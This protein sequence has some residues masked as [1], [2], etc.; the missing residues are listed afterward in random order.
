MREPTRVSWRASCLLCLAGAGSCVS[1][2]FVP[3]GG[4]VT[5]KPVDCEIQVFSSAVPERPYV[6]MGIVEGEGSW[7]KSD[8]EDVLPKLKE[9]A[10]LAGGDAIIMQSTD[11]FAEGEDGIRVQ[12]ITAT[13]IR[14]ARQ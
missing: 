11:T 13:V 3:T 2:T 5:P 9:E 10:C 7:W 1:A 8:L 12:R 6:E 14:W 4:A